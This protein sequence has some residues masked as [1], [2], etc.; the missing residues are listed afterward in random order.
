V[1]DNI[2][3]YSAAKNGS[4]K[5]VE[6]LLRDPRVD[7]ADGLN[8]SLCG[9][10]KGGNL[11]VTELLIKDARVSAGVAESYPFRAA[12]HFHNEALIKL[13]LENSRETDPLA[14]GFTASVQL[15]SL[16]KTYLSKMLCDRITA[17]YHGREKFEEAIGLDLEDVGNDSD[18]LSDS[19]S[20]TDSQESWDTDSEESWNTVESD[21]SSPE[22]S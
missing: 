1:D 8:H 15:L 12:C 5:L 6:K 10:A 14:K 2:C 18:F 16:E 7:P 11:E 19:S 22:D 3:I 20:T 17:L 21:E 4:L 9:A 13:F